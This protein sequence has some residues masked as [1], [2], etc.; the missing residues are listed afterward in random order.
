MGPV[1]SEHTSMSYKSTYPYH[2][3]M[4]LRDTLEKAEAQLVNLEA[5][6]APLKVVL[7]QSMPHIHALSAN[8][9]TLDQLTKFLQ[10]HFHPNNHRYAQFKAEWHRQNKS[11][12]DMKAL[13]EDPAFLGDLKEEEDKHRV[14]R[15]KMEQ[16]DQL[17]ADATRGVTVEIIKERIESAI[18]KKPISPEDPPL[19]EVMLSRTGRT[20][21]RTEYTPALLLKTVKLSDTHT[22]YIVSYVGPDNELISAFVE[23]Q[24]FGK[25]LV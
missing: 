14:K 20:H 25:Y 10:D 3:A 13:M 21:A 12:A 16:K 2:T 1:R 22:E 15:L 7:E 6:M 8:A 19:I 9:E 18:S 11:I 4:G 5:D 17:L 23:W 24:H